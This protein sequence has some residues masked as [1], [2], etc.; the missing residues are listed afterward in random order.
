MEDTLFNDFISGFPP[1]THQIDL[2]RFAK[3]AV[4]AI[5]NGNSF[6]LRKEELRNS[7]EGDIC[8]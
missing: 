2:G 4:Y 1:Y 3:Y 5:R 6:D 7:L 8:E